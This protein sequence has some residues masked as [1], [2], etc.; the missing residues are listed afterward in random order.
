V[1]DVIFSPDS[2]MVV[3]ASDDSTIRLWDTSTGTTC[4]KLGP[5]QGWERGM[6]F[7]RDGK[8]V[9]STADDMTVRILETDENLWSLK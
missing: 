7:A 8:L 6:A 2:K 1:K 5:V 9:V 3:S 4:T